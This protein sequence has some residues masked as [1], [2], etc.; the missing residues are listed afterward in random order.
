M[1]L[2]R[3][4][5][6][7]GARREQRFVKASHGLRSR[8]LSHIA[9]CGFRGAACVC[10]ER[11]DARARAARSCGS[12]RN[13]DAEPRRSV[14]S[15]SD[16]HLGSSR[17]ATRVVFRPEAGGGGLARILRACACAVGAD[18]PPQWILRF[19]I[20]V[21]PSCLRARW[22]KTIGRK[23][24]LLNKETYPVRCGAGLGLT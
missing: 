7:L 23:T 14:R 20:G 18:R 1:A 3:G 4:I 11:S 17:R 8:S 10:A 12:H 5:I 19:G 22:L 2:T 24:R 9:R 6:K 21:V 13:S 15:T 16:K